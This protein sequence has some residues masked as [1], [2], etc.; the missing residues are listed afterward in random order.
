VTAAILFL[1]IFL[2]LSPYLYIRLSFSILTNLNFVVSYLILTQGMIRDPFDEFFVSEGDRLA[3]LG[4]DSGEFVASDDYWEKRYKA[5]E[6]KCP[7][8]LKKVETEILKAGKYLNVIRQCGKD[9]HLYMVSRCSEFW[10]L[11]VPA[12][13]IV[14]YEQPVLNRISTASKFLRPFSP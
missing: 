6:D 8:F 7:S 10:L 14:C 12:R 11:P 9:L 2:L 13:F 5:E 1:S 4:S 3:G